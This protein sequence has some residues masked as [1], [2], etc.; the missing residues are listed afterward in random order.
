MLL[1]YAARGVTGDREGKSVTTVGALSILAMHRPHQAGEGGSIPTSALFRK[2]DWWVET[3]KLDIGRAMV[4]RYHYAA[5]GS[6]TAVYLHGLFPRGAWGNAACA[7]AAW[8]IPPTKGAA[9]KTCPANWE[10]VL[11]LSRLVV[12]PGV[13]TN[14]CS[15]LMRHSMRMIDRRRWPLLLTY[16]DEWRGHEGKIYLAAGWEF[17]GWTKPERCYV[18]NGKMASRKA[19]PKTRTH[20]EMLAL[21]YECVGRFRKKRFVHRLH[22]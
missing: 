22:G 14:A 20:A 15:Y 2:A 16:A 13:P 21:G 6:N 18:R 3:C 12:V 4:D 1:R 11:A 9:L 8:W 17:N 10:G 19:G 7:G 5:G